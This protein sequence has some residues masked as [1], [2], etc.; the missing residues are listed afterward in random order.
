MKILIGCRAN[1]NIYPHNNQSYFCFYFILFYYYF[2]IFLFYLFIFFFFACEKKSGQWSL[3][4]E[5]TTMCFIETL[6]EDRT[7]TQNTILIFI[8]FVFL[9]TL[10]FLAWFAVKIRQNCRR[11]SIFL[12]KQRNNPVSIVIV[13]CMISRV[14]FTSKWQMGKGGIVTE[15]TPPHPRLID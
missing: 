11:N 6:Y 5:G 7:R 10:L 12:Q 15:R 2:F 3:F 4:S 9:W 13:L 8:L 1:E 14:S